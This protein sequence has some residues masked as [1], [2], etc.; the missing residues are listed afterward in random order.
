VP[1]E[2][3]LDRLRVDLEG[4]GDAETDEIV[5]AEGSADALVTRAFRHLESDDLHPLTHEILARLGGAA[6]LPHGHEERGRLR[7]R[8]AMK[9]LREHSPSN[10]GELL[11][12]ARQDAGVS[13][14]AASVLLGISPAAVLRLEGGRA[15]G[16]LLNQPAERVA[17]YIRQIRAN[18]RDLLAALFAVPHPGVVYGYTPQAADNERARLLKRGPGEAGA[19]DREWALAFLLRAERTE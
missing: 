7:A 15:S 16:I 10:P 3:P 5:E 14:H 9:R 6:D 2:D 4:E 18:P 13:E 12:E 17:A 11:R 19:R 8:L 1:T